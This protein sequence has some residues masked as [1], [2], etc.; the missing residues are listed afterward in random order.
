MKWELLSQEVEEKTKKIISETKVM[1]LGYEGCL[2]RVTSEKGEAIQFLK[3]MS[4]N[5]KKIG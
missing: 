4:Y 3:G 1:N 5:E 2:I